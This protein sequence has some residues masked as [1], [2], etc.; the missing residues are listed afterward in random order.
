MKF[1]DDII[2]CIGVLEKGG[3]ILYP[4]DTIWGLGCDA[5]NDLAIEKIFQL[6]KRPSSKTMILLVD[7]VEMVRQYV[8]TANENLLNFLTKQKEP[9]TGIFNDAD[10]LPN[11]LIHAD[12]TIAI[13]ITQDEFCKELINKFGKPIVS[14]SANFSG[15]AP[16]TQFSEIDP[17]IKNAV[18][19]IV[20]FRRAESKTAMPSRIVKLGTNN[21]VTFLR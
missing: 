12:G 21:E 18:D 11:A 10:N 19:Y 3:V 7:S 13:R 17:L 1:E 8:S 9:T 6:K 5:T 15:H 20:H 2:K 14:T 4:T 16:A